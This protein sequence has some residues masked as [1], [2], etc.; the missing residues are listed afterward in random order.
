MMADARPPIPRARLEVCVDTP[1]GV[2]AAEMNGADRI[3]LCSALA[4][5]GLTPSPGLMRMASACNIPVR[6]MIRPCEGD[7]TYSP[8]EVGVMELDIDAAAQSHLDGVVFC[9]N[10]LDGALDHDALYRLCGRAKRQGLTVAL[11]L[12]FDLAPSPL[13]ALDMAV[14]LNVDTILTAGGAATAR[15]GVAGLAALTAAAK[16]RIEI[17]AGR[18]V[19][20]QDVAELNARAGITAFHASCSRPLPV[21]NAAAAAR[22]Y[23]TPAQRDTDPLRVA[24]LRQILNTLPVET[25][26]V[27]R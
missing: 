4:V 23:V 16:G 14:A 19:T 15:E 22:G 20:G 26:H 9:A 3:E 24:K 2:R 27:V 17:L 25:A 18:G 7:F 8:D 12:G 1:A 13:D 5:G 10:H 11:H 21:R 6:A